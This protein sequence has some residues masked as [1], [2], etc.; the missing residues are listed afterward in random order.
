MAPTKPGFA[1]LGLS[2]FR[3]LHSAQPLHQNITSGFPMPSSLESPPN[4]VF[5][6]LVLLLCGCDKANDPV[7]LSIK[8][9]TA[10]LSFM[11]LLCSTHEMKP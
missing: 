7:S 4:I 5:R 9:D 2:P 3:S 11:E 6:S 10:I 1:R 8:Q